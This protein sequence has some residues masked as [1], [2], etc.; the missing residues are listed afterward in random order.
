MHIMGGRSTVFVHPMVHVLAK[1][2]V[3]LRGIVT[4]VEEMDLSLPVDV[5]GSKI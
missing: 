2:N 1:A 4:D 5:V 3:L